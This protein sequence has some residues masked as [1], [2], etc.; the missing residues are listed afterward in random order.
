VVPHL[1]TREWGRRAVL[2]LVLSLS[3]THP[4]AAVADPVVVYFRPWSPEVEEFHCVV[5]GV[6][7][8]PVCRQM[9]GGLWSG[10]SEP[11]WER[12]L[13][14]L[15]HTESAWYDWNYDGRITVSDMLAAFRAI[16]EA[17]Y[18]GLTP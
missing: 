2:F 8:L 11:A 9:V 10:W 17:I 14:D 1:G 4:Q 15:A 3:M 16:N 12:D 13:I 18:E 6:T 7:N 5:D